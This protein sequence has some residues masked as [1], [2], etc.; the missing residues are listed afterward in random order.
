MAED[1][2]K[3]EQL[4]KIEMKMLDAIGFDLGA[5]L[6]YSYLRRYSRV[7]HGDMETL[8]LSRY[9]LETLQL[10][11]EFVTVSDSKL[12][13]ASFLLALKMKKNGDGW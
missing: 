11:Y 6:S 10:F 12:A 2:F 13:A 5:P 3:R 7:I 9:I 8:T 4:I 1:T